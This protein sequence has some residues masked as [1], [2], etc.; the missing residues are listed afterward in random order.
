MVYATG[1]GLIACSAQDGTQGFARSGPYTS[2]LAAVE[3]PSYLTRTLATTSTGGLYGL[4]AGGG[5]AIPGTDRGI[6]TQRW[7]GPPRNEYRPTIEHTPTTNPVAVDGTIYT[8]VVGTNDLVAVNAANGSVHWRTTVVDDEVISA[9][10]GRPAVDDDAV[11]IANWPNRVSAYDRTD[12]T[13]LWQREREEQM[14]LSTSVTDAGVVVTT[15][16]GVALLDTDDGEPIWERDLDGNA[17]SGAPAVTTERVLVGDGLEEFH[18]LDLETGEVEWS[19]P[20]EGETKP[21][22]ADG[23]VYAVERNASL[24]ALDVDSGEERFRYEPPEVPLSPPIVGDERLFLV[25]RSRIL[26]L[27]GSR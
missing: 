4:N 26:A 20:F 9:S 18:A 21:V 1:G 24:V 2:S 8:P 11:Y 25:N 23:I 7:S 13:L 15:R 3:A 16:S 19:I 17:T 6:G 14:Q 10:F 5:I 27:E 22:V 12:G